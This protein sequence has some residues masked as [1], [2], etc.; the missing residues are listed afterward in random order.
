VPPRRSLPWAAIVLAAACVLAGAIAYQFRDRVFNKNSSIES[1]AGEERRSIESSA[2]S[3]PAN[4]FPWSLE[5]TNAVFPDQPT[6][7]RLRGRD[8]QPNKT[9]LQGGVLTFRQGKSAPSDLV[10]SVMLHAA[11]G[12]DLAGKLVQVRSEQARAPTILVRWKSGETRL[13]TER[14]RSGYA[15]RLLFGQP[16]EG[17]MPGKIWL[18]LPDLDQSFLSGTFEAEIR[19]PPPPKKTPPQAP[20]PAETSRSPG[21]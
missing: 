1:L 21:K 4:T 3:P 12:E 2:D 16:S 9:I 13:L 14:H 7:G 10:L 15:L 6:L 17:R 19:V 11:R 5:V 8:F 18:S 20:E